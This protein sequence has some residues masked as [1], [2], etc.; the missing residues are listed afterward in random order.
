MASK[1]SPPVAIA[2]AA[3]FGATPRHRLQRHQP[4][5]A[6]RDSRGDGVAVRVEQVARVHQR[7][8]DGKGVALGGEQTR[9]GHQPV[10]V[11]ALQRQ[12]SERDVEAQRRARHV[13]RHAGLEIL[14]RHR[15]RQPA[16]ELADVMAETEIVAEGDV[17]GQQR[18]TGRIADL[19]GIV[20]GQ[21][22][23]SENDVHEILEGRAQTRR[24]LLRRG[25][26][27]SCC[28][29]AAVLTMT[30]SARFGTGTPGGSTSPT[31]GS[32]GLA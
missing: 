7:Q 10:R 11:D 14:S 26:G 22:R 16:A 24:A 18:R 28:A 1:R 13:P 23:L 17:A 15:P 30:S 25:A 27:A 2:F 6:A 32:S 5:P 9:R 29:S 20:Q 31:L 8:A 3:A 21:Q 12:T 4:P 19:G